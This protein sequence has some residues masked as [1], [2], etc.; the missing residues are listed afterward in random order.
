MLRAIL[1]I[2]HMA[3]HFNLLLTSRGLPYLFAH[4]NMRLIL[5]LGIYALSPFDLLPEAFLGPLGLLDDGLA[6]GAILSQLTSM[7]YGYLRE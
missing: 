7:L 4:P 2:P 5:L 6:T 1:E 3:Q